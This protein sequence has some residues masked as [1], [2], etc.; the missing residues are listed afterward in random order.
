MQESDLR[1]D[2]YRS[3]GAG[4]QSVN[5]TDSAVRITHLPTGL[6]VAMQVGLRRLLA[7]PCCR[8]RGTAAAW[9][10]SA[11]AERAVL[12]R[13]SARST[14]TRPRRSRS[15]RWGGCSGGTRPHL[16]CPGADARGAGP[17]ARL[18]DAQQ[19]T[20]AAEHSRQ[21]RGLAGSGDRSERVRTYNFPQVCCLLLSLHARLPTQR[22][23]AGSCSVTYGA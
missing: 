2:T 23:A 13:T 3:G 4:G 12:G 17:Q 1:I 10:D 8:A 9:R 7:L 22:S 18:Y 21:R 20:A 5:T 19:R 15:C 6:V 11:A 16:R 14:R